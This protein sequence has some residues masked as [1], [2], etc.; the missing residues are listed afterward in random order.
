LIKD[1]IHKVAWARIAKV[2]PELGI[3]LV[4]LENKKYQRTFWI[5]WI[6][7]KRE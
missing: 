3:W 2:F 4:D 1:K 5:Y 6:S 7:T